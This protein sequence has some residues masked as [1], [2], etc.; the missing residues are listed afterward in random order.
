VRTHERGLDLSRRFYREVV[1]DLVG[2]VAHA[3]SLIG[4]GSE[5]L[6]F[7][8]QRSTDH[9]WGLRLQVFVAAEHVDE[10]RTRLDDALPEMFDGWP[11]R[12]YRWQV[13][14]VAHHVEVSSVRDWLV[15]WLKFDP[16]DG[17]T[18]ARWL[19]TPQQL[20][21]EVTAGEVFHDG[22]GELTEVRD[23]LRWYPNEVW[24]WLMSCEWS[25]VSAYEPLVGRTA[26]VGDKLGTQLAAAS[27]SRH[28]ARLRLLQAQR[29][30][31]Y[32]KWLG[33]A[34]AAVDA[35]MPVLLAELTH[36]RDDRSREAAL[37]AV[38]V[39]LAANHNALAVTDHVEARLDD[40][41]VRIAG[42]HRPYRVL[43]SS[44]FADALDAQLVGSDLQKLGRVGAIDQLA[45]P[46]DEMIH[47]S[48]WSARLEAIYNDKLAK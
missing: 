40:Y 28:V 13:A 14:G 48:D 23:Q 25:R 36:A 6:G 18:T 7:D 16:R 21:L 11:V 47:F 43:N 32:A 22:I 15:D 33:S 44:R 46:T 17:M 9:A 38:L 3:A 10:I 42:A 41:D 37:G 19:A 8:T 20:L 1:R 27:L 29:Y 45:R 34:L 4:E 12:Y 35:A 5:V 24:L 30:S 39:H 2:D 31:P 26:E